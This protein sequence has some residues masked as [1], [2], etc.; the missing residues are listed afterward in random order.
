MKTQAVIRLETAIKKAGAEGEGAKVQIS[1]ATAR[2]LLHEIEQ[3]DSLNRTYF[4]RLEAARDLLN[5][6]K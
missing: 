1:Q 3:L 2:M 4:G 5:Q 6:T